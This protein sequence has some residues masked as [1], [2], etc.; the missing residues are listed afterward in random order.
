MPLQENFAKQTA[1]CLQSGFKDPACTHMG[2]KWMFILFLVC[3]MGQPRGCRCLCIPAQH[4]HAVLSHEASP[5]PLFLPAT[6]MGLSARLSLYSEQPLNEP[7]HCVF[8]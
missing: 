1:Y 7:A 6:L 4:H 5:R 2:V 3:N 8:N